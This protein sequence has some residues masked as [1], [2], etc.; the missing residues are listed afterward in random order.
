MGHIFI[1]TKFCV[2]GVEGTKFCFKN[3]ILHLFIFFFTL[4]LLFESDLFS[5]FQV[6]YMINIVFLLQYCWQPI[7]DL[8]RQHF[9]A[10]IQSFHVNDLKIILPGNKHIFLNIFKKD[11]SFKIWILR[12]LQIMLSKWIIKYTYNRQ[13]YYR[14]H[15]NAT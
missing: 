8:T 2:W 12:K 9:D 11:L 10:K 3:Q 14:Y 13:K 5:T 6:I 4:K 7:K 1:Q 15:Q